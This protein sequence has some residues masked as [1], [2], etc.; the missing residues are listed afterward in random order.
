[1]PM[2]TA[3]FPM[4]FYL[5]TVCQPV[6]HDLPTKDIQMIPFP[7][8][9]AGYQAGALPGSFLHQ[10]P[11]GAGAA[12]RPREAEGCGKQICQTLKLKTATSGVGVGSWS[13]F[14]DLS[15]KLL[16]V[17]NLVI[18]KTKHLLLNGAPCLPAA[19]R[20]GIIWQSINKKPGPKFLEMPPGQSMLV[21]FSVAGEG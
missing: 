16:S 5:Q 21:C 20:P 6:C 19:K 1:M 15:F 14:S 7:V 10:G 17:E 11:E 13:R 3:V 8:A 12:G 2:S 4:K 18:C 9:I